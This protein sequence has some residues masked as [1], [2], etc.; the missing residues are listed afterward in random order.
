MKARELII[1]I[2]L[3]CSLYVQFWTGNKPSQTVLTAGALHRA[4]EFC[5]KQ[6]KGLTWRRG[7]Y[8]EIQSVGCLSTNPS[9]GKD[10][11]EEIPTYILQ[12]ENP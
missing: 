1:L 10:E 6:R 7:Y 5:D 11:R 9:T 4:Q 2:A 8:D 12:G 3:V